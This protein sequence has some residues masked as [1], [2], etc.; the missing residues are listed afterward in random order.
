[1]GMM[2]AIK[3]NKHQRRGQNIHPV[4]TFT[5]E[6]QFSGKKNQF[7]VKRSQQARTNQSHK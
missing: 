4:V 5:A 1:M 6:T 7:V 3:D 2:E